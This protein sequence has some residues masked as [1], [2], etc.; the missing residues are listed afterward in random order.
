MSMPLS[1]K[2]TLRAAGVAP[3][4]AIR[5]ALSRRIDDTLF[6]IW[7]NGC[8]MMDAEDVAKIL[9]VIVARDHGYRIPH[10]LRQR[11]DAHRAAI[12]DA[13]ETGEMN[14]VIDA[15]NAW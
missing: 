3:G 8:G 4:G 11:F 14:S 1:I 9:F 5:A 10:W 13:V 6:A 15:V 12:I 2:A 7:E